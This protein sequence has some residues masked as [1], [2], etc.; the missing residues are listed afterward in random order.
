MLASKRLFVITQIYAVIQG[1]LYHF[2]LFGCSSSGAGQTILLG[3]SFSPFHFPPYM[4]FSTHHHGGFFFF[5]ASKRHTF[6]W[7][8]WSGES[9]LTCDRS[10]FDINISHHNVLRLLPKCLVWVFLVSV[11][12]WMGPEL[13]SHRYWWR[14]IN[15]WQPGSRNLVF[16]ISCLWT[17]KHGSQKSWIS[18]EWNEALSQSKDSSCVYIYCVYIIYDSWFICVYTRYRF[19][20]QLD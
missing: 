5:T 11:W 12:V 20:W 4:N 10:V 6:N 8:I 14:Q 3:P 19:S 18:T 13:L 9:T 15:F 7:H 1:H 16:R 2:K 17:R